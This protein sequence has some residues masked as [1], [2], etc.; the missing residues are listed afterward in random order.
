MAKSQAWRK[1]SSVLRQGLAA[2]GGLRARL[3]HV[4][5]IGNTRMK[6]NVQGHH[7]GAGRAIE[8]AS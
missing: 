8:D 4:R 7:W 2:P 6:S 5:H 3:T 1:S